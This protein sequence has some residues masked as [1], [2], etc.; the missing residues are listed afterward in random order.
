MDKR[1]QSTA[2]KRAAVESEESRSDS[3][4]HCWRAV[5]LGAFLNHRQP[6]F[7]G[8]YRADGIRVHST[9]SLSWLNKAM[10]CLMHFRQFLARGACSGNAV[11]VVDATV[12]RPFRDVMRW[13]GSW[14]EEP[15]RP[16]TNIIENGRKLPLRSRLILIVDATE[17]LKAIVHSAWLDWSEWFPGKVET[18]WGHPKERHFLSIFHR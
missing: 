17:G 2:M 18:D 14:P 11:A 8:L 16:N 5:T 7:P 1:Q 3:S 4:T 13:Q 6:H 15:K 12:S 10:C 9:V